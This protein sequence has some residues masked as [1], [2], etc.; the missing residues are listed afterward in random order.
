LREQTRKLDK[1]IGEV[2]TE[3]EEF[4]IEVFTSKVEETIISLLSCGCLL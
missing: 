2:Y 4:I 3:L 1:E